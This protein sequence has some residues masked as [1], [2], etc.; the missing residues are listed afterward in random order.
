MVTL[1]RSWAPGFLAGPESDV[2]NNPAT[3]VTMLG[4][5]TIFRLFQMREVRRMVF[6]G[7]YEWYASMSGYETEKK[8]VKMVKPTSE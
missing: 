4:T 5:A 2:L 1:E 6:G 7:G 8:V 3:T